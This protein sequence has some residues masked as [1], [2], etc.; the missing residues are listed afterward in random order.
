MRACA[1]TKEHRAE[2]LV[3]RIAADVGRHFDERTDARQN[4]K[5]LPSFLNDRGVKDN[6]KD[7][8]WIMSFMK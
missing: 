5:E 4:K 6:V 2:G 8:L 1:S 3:S 7:T